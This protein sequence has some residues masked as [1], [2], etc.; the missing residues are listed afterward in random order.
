MELGTSYWFLDVQKTPLHVSSSSVA[1][2]PL[3]CT[4]W[5]M[6]QRNDRYP[7]FRANWSATARLLVLCVHKLATVGFALA[8][9]KLHRLLT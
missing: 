3:D 6:W 8:E 7:E 5:K 9:Q 2:I 4:P 1:T